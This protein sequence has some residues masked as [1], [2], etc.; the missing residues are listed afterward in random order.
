MRTK[1]GIGIIF[2]KAQLSAKFHC[3]AST[4]TLFS[5]DGEVIE[6]HS[7]PVI[8]NQKRPTSSGETIIY[9]YL[10]YVRHRG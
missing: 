1:F 6:S 2:R 4:V 5:K 8:E 10:C 3:P 9:D 7:S